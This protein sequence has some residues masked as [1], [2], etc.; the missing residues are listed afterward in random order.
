M[1]IKTRRLLISPVGSDADPD[2]FLAIFNSNPDYLE[3]SEGKRRYSRGDAESYL[4][5][6][7]AREHGR[8]LAIRRRN[9]G[10]LVG[11]A[12]LV[13]PHPDGYPWIGL[14]II[15]GDRQRKGFGREAALAIE[16]ALAEEGW[17]EVRLGVLTRNEQA[18]PFWQGGGYSIVRQADSSTGLP[19][20]VLAKS[21]IRA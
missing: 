12:A 15:D 9:D 14:L 17:R 3:A 11:T 13:V 4:F 7:T 10:R 8:C 18:L 6:E 1:T 5:A 19:C 16:A 2:E 21:L 20:W